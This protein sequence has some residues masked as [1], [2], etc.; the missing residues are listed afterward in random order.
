MLVLVGVACTGK[1]APVGERE[2]PII[3]GSETS[4]F[5]AVALIEVGDARC[6]ATLVADTVLLTAAHC[7]YDAWSAGERRGRAFFGPS[8]ADAT[9]SIEIEAIL[10][11]YLYRPKFIREADVGLV[12][13]AQAPSGIVPMVWNR[14]PLD[15]TVLGAAATVVGFGVDDGEGQTGAGIK[16]EVGLTIDVVEPQ[17]FGLGDDTENICQGDSGGPTFLDFGGTLR[18]VAVSSF[19]S[20]FCQNRSFVTRTDAFVDFIDEVVQAWSGPCQQ[21]FSCVTDGCGTFPDPDCGLCGLEGVCGQDCATRDLDCPP[22]AV[23]GELCA[24][25]G[26]CELGM[27]VQAED[28]PTVFFCSEPCDVAVA[29]ADCSRDLDLCVD[30]DGQGTCVYS[31]ITPTTQGAPCEAGEDCR[32]GICDGNHGICVERC[33]GTCPAPFSCENFGDVRV[34][35]YEHGGCCSLAPGRKGPGPGPGALLILAAF[36]L[37]LWQTRR[38]VR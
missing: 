11:H 25:D 38:Q 15:D 29:G 1:P 16:R 35:T 36:G 33:D 17:L 26:D 9:E 37:F 14:E 12:R 6:T 23:P 10:P 20:N 27:C 31:G 32:S 28:N 19:G 3:G 21:D 24:D 7:I 8:R 5:P 2:T 34:C 4:E 18:V 13:L 30:R 22:L